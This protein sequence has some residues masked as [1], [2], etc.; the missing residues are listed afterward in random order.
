MTRST[1]DLSV[2]TEVGRKSTTECTRNLPGDEG[3][4][5]RQA[6]NL[7]AVC[8]NRLSRKSGSLDVS[9]VCVPPWPATW[10]YLLLIIISMSLLQVP[11][12]L[13]AYECRLAP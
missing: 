13:E 9:Q 4:P 3:R 7:T 12:K 2:R 5:V 11:S 1:Y 6:D 8:V 10:V